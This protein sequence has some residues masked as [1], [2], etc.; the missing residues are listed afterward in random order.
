MSGE[1]W[2]ALGDIFV[3][4]VSVGGYLVALLLGWG[5]Q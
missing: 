5:G 3:V 1:R 4:A 2:D